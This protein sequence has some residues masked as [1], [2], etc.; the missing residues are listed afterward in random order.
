MERLKTG[1]HETNFNVILS[2][3]LKTGTH[4]TNFNFNVIFSQVLKN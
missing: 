4:E 2:Q 3:V 1:T